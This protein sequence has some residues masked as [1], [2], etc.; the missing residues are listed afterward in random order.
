[1]DSAGFMVEAMKDLGHL[2]ARASS[3]AVSAR[4]GLWLRQWSADTESKKSV[5]N[6]PFTGQALFGEVL[7]AWIS[8]AT[9]DSRSPLTLTLYV[10]Q[11]G[12][13]AL[14]LPCAQ[15]HGPCCCQRMEGEDC[16]RGALTIAC[17]CFPC[18]PLILSSSLAC[19]GCWSSSRL[20]KH[21]DTAAGVPVRDA[22]FS[23]RIVRQKKT[24]SRETLEKTPLPPHQYCTVQTHLLIPPNMGKAVVPNDADVG[25]GYQS[26]Y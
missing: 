11:R 7:D 16:C 26:R 3:M 25:G 19:C 15:S 12:E 6:L 8:T 17:D 18:F 2:N 13:S 21:T 23:L 22:L 5:E 14:Y 24:A 10:D 1:M 9:G 20:I 4:R